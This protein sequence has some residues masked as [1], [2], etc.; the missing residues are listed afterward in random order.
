MTT[1]TTTTSSCPAPTTC[2]NE[3]VQWAY[4]Y[5]NPDPKPNGGDYFDTFDPAALKTIT[6]QYTNT[7]SYI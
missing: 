7:T 4:Y 5:P 1:T 2:G 6:P 3:G